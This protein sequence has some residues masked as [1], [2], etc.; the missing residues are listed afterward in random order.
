MGFLTFDPIYQLRPWGG[1]KL[2]SYLHRTLPAGQVGESWDI[3]DRSEA[4]S[5]VAKGLYRG[6]PLADLLAAHREWLMGPDWPPGQPFPI[7]VKWLD[8]AER[9]SLQVHPPADIARKLNAEPKTELW[10]VAQA[11]SGA[12]LMAGLREPMTQ[13]QFE[14][15]LGSNAIEACIHRIPVRAGDAL[16]V[17][18]GRIHAIDAG[19]LILEIQE[20]SDTTYRVYDWGRTGLDGK[21][22]ALHIRES[23]LCSDFEDVRPGLV[24]QAG[25][26]D[27]L[28]DCSSFRVT[29]FR[30][31]QG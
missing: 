22:R 23:L 24:P 27:I 26:Q 25:P 4:C 5:A 3:V 19:N 9:L 12:A 28:A 10:Y 6:K 20:N 14:Q 29:R 13:L 30:L 1:R 31:A 11:D 21:P 15:C 7:L 18:S 8:C 16:F 17:P 2:E